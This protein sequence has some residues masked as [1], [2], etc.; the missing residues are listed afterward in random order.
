MKTLIDST[1]D[2]CFFCVGTNAT[3]NSKLVRTSPKHSW[4]FHISNHPSGHVVWIPPEKREPT[5]MQIIR[6]AQLC[7][8][9][10]KFKNSRRITVE[11]TPLSNII[12]IE[13]GGQV[14]IQK[15]KRVLSICV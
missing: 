10:S 6:G 5:R 15:P 8:D 2:T 7:K 3:E 4:W 9:Q 11:Y 14:V 12:P 1:D 13:N